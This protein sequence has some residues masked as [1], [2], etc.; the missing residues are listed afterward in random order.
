[1]SYVCCQ[2]HSIFNSKERF[3]FPF[4]E[5]KI[6]LNGIYI[7]FEK[8]E[9]AHNMDRIVRI[10]THTGTNQLPSRLKQHFIIE[11]KDRSI[12]RKNIGRCLLNMRKDPYLKLWELDL[13]TRQL[14]DKYSGLINLEYQKT[15]EKEITH[16]LQKNLSFCVF[17]VDSKE[18][19]IKIE[20]ILIST[21]STCKECNPSAN[22][23]GLQSPIEKIRSS[24]LWNIQGLYKESQALKSLEELKA[25]Q[26]TFKVFE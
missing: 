25:F 17:Q 11:N 4:Q 2:L 7:L 12:F 13:T 24:G 6:P 3:T 23:L 16:Y 21:I 18:E 1:M 26:N 8:G 14:K 22:W 19:R 20:E 10:G 15:I 9:H 5:S